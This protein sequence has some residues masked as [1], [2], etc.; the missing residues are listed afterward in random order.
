MVSPVHKRCDNIPDI[1]RSIWSSTNCKIFELFQFWR[2]P[3]LIDI[4]I[5][6]Y[7]RKL[8]NIDLN[9]YN[10]IKFFGLECV[11]LQV[12]GVK[13]NIDI[14][15]ITNHST[16]KKTCIMISA[17]TLEEIINNNFFEVV[18]ELFK[19]SSIVLF[20]GLYPNSISDSNLENLTSGK[21]KSISRCNKE[22]VFY[23]VTK[24]QNDIC[25]AFSG[26]AIRQI[27]HDID[28]GLEFDKEA[29]NVSSLIGI[30]N[31][32]LFLK[33]TDNQN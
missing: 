5:I 11:L 24:N 6:I 3:I 20:Y 26:L 21:V 2:T 19:S 16:E 1:K 33:I 12:C 29:E 9:L 18:S 25:G 17:S 10:I 15:S 32:S 30:D 23:E 7:S 22:S 13:E 31:K 4:P 14:S 8:S 28:A 27:D